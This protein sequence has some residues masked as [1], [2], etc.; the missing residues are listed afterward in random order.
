MKHGLLDPEP[1]SQIKE[2]EEW[3]TICKMLGEMLNIS[4]AE[5]NKK[6]EVR[7]LMAQIEKW[8]Y[9]ECRRR[10]VCEQTEMKA[11]VFWNDE[12]QKEVFDKK[13][14]SEIIA[15]MNKIAKGL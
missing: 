2:H 8:G 5:F 7:P 15:E 12:P 3:Q 1:Y 9:W 4:Q 10:I 13:K 14:K 11:G 6:K